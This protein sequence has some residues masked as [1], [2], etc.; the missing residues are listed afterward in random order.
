MS[1]LHEPE[2]KSFWEACGPL[3]CCETLDDLTKDI[4]KNKN[5]IEPCRKWL[6]TCNRLKN[7][8]KNRDTLRLKHDAES[9]LGQWIPHSIFIFSAFLDGFELK[10]AGKRDGGEEWVFQTNVGKHIKPTI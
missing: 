9:D 4:M 10:P 8:N 7:I 2:I 5:M 1:I 3:D 6:S